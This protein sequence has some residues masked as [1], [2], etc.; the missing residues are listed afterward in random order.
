MSLRL[1]LVLIILLPLLFIAGLIGTWAVYDAQLRAS[2][3]FDRSLLSAVLAVS[4][5]VAV[6]GGDALSPETSV[7]LQDTS[8]GRVFYHVYAPDGVFVTG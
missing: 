6:S 4:R 5:D 8:G 3:R 2:E 1:R 7:L